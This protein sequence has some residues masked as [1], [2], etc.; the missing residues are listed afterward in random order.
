MVSHGVTS[1]TLCPA[2][3]YSSAAGA[4]ECTPAPA[5][6]YASGTGNT[7]PT[8]CPA[9][10]TSAAGASVC[11]PIATIAQE[12]SDAIDAALSDNQGLANSMHQQADGISSA[13]N[14]NAKAGKLGAFINHVNAQRG[15]ALT[16]AEA[17]NL[18]ALAELL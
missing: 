13:L 17:D 5:G 8:L 4:A 2:G 1:A 18:I 3:T 16:P 7:S 6:F 11:T 10:T 9:G 14:A 12:L 15:K